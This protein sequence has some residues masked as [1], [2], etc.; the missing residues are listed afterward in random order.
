MV[1][2]DDA[3]SCLSRDLPNPVNAAWRWSTQWGKCTAT[4]RQKEKYAEHRVIQIL[5]VISEHSRK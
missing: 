1:P 2:K 4:R 3:L 5:D